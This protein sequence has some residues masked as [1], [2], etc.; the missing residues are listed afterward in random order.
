MRSFLQRIE[1]RV[2]LKID[3]EDGIRDAGLM[4]LD[5]RRNDPGTHLDS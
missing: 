3:H 4:I 2:V 5:D 1:E